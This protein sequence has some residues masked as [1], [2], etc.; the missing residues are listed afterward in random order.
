MLLSP[1]QLFSL[2]APVFLTGKAGT[3][4]VHKQCKAVNASCAPFD[5]GCCPG[6]ICA[7]PNTNA[8]FAHVFNFQCKGTMMVKGPHLAPNTTAG[9]CAFTDM[10]CAGHFSPPPPPPS[11]PPPSTTTY[12]CPQGT[13]TAD[14]SWCP[15]RYGRGRLCCERPNIAYCL[16]PFKCA[17]TQATCSGKSVHLTKEEELEEFEG[18]LKAVAHKNVEA[19][20]HHKTKG[21]LQP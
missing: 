7:Y 14:R 2:A 13:P 1:F 8:S 10:S 11:S 16:C 18:I 6:T 3:G 9:Y 5:A 4:T 21:V 20:K 15:R 17:E 12:T 19:E